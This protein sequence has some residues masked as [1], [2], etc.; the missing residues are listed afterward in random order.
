MSGA[1]IQVRVDSIPLS[2][3][4][5][6]NLEPPH[7]SGIRIPYHCYNGHI[8]AASSIQ[9]FIFSELAYSK[10]VHYKNGKRGHFYQAFITVRRDLNPNLN[11]GVTRTVEPT[12]TI[13]KIHFF[14]ARLFKKV[15]IIRMVKEVILPGI[16]LATNWATKMRERSRD[17][18]LN[19]IDTVEFL[20]QLCPRGKPISNHSYNGR[21]SK[22]MFCSEKPCR[23]IL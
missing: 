15:S 4:S 23:R 5:N 14:G 20:G 13:P 12:Y 11:R 16:F 3:F 7:W 19:K 10:S 9:K 17:R 21:K 6:K 22:P 18:N 2:P 8:F 1:K